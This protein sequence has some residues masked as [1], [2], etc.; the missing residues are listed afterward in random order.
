MAKAESPGSR[1][2]KGRIT[3]DEFEEDVIILRSYSFISVT[4][5][6]A[7]FEMHRLVQLA[8]QKWL[9]S[10][11]RLER[12]GSQFVSNLDDAFP[13]GKYEEWA[14]CQPL[15]PHAMAALDMNLLDTEAKLWQASLLLKS[16]RYASQQGAFDSAERMQSLAMKVR[17]AVLPEGHLDTLNTMG[18]LSRIY[19]NQG[20]WAEAEKLQVEVMETSKAVLPEGHPDTLTSMDNL[21]RIYSNQGRWDGAEKLQVEVM[22]TGKA[23]LPK[24]HPDTLRSMGNLAI[25]QRNLDWDQGIQ[26]PSVAA[27][28]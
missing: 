13:S 11:G 18:N 21:S 12:W 16:G 17:K 3:G 1:R 6:L 5:D 19:S 23:V 24:G 28:G 26:T 4:A 20:R 25:I 15:L 7:S 22:E 9:K 14:V 2:D 10:R 8:T 27:D